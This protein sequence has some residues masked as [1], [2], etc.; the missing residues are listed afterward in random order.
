MTK[1][2]AKVMVPFVGD[3][4]ETSFESTWKRMPDE[5]YE[6]VPTDRNPPSFKLVDNYEFEDTLIYK[7]YSKCS[8][9]INFI[10]EGLTTKKLYTLFL[11]DFEKIIPLLKQG[12][13]T[14]RWTFRNQSGYTGCTLIE[15]VTYIDTGLVVDYCSNCKAKFTTYTKDVTDGIAH[16]PYCGANHILTGDGLVG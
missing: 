11:T 8:S 6:R 10:F 9:R 5:T 7:K 1:E 12:K 16:C 15:G 13:V 14:G 3:I 2:R 4:Q